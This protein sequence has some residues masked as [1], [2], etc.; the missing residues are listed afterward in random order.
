MSKTF[1]WANQRSKVH[2]DIFDK[3]AGFNFE[4]AIAYFERKPAFVSYLSNLLCLHY[5]SFNLMFSLVWFT[6]DIRVMYLKRLDP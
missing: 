3:N 5:L 1:R 6:T 2:D 4:D